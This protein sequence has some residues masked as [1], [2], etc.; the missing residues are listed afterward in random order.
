MAVL[1]D[2]D[3]PSLFGNTPYN[4]K[5]P[6]YTRPPKDPKDAANFTPMPQPQ[7][8]AIARFL[9]NEARGAAP[10]HDPEGEK[11]VRQRCT[12][13]H[14]FRGDTDDAQGLAPELAGW[15]SLS[16]TRA[17]IGNPGTNLTYRP[18]ALSPALEGHM[19]RFDAQLSP[20]DLDLLTRFVLFRAQKS[21]KLPTPGQHRSPLAPALGADGDRRLAALPSPRPWAPLAPRST[22]SWGHASPSLPCPAAAPP[23]RSRTDPRPGLRRRLPGRNQGRRG[24]R[25]QRR[26]P[27]LRGRRHRRGGAEHPGG[28]RLRRRQQDPPPLG[29]DRGRGAPL[30]DPLHLH[31]ERLQ[32][33]T[34]AAP[35][36]AR[37][38]AQRPRPRHPVHRRRLHPHVPHRGQ[39]QGAPRRHQQDLLHPRR[40]RLER[41]QGSRR[42]PL[43]HPH[44][45]PHREQPRR[46]RR[47]PLHLQQGPLLLHRP[48][49]RPRCTSR[50]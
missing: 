14:L 47:R 36:L 35:P 13:C 16:W 28:H 46:R 6:S 30:R 23:R 17:Q 42:P 37:P 41:P 10:G 40:G 45:R 43:P 49:T 39:P 21:Q 11:L 19:P 26:R 31:L 48:L 1:D 38:R 7:R 5:M 34:P 27:A 22:L 9:A 12:T 50:G 2:P 33:S 15:A 32:R 29:P 18:V 20:A 24:P 44:R 4:G 8:E 25:R 3:S